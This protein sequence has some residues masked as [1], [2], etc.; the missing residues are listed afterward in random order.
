MFARR[1]KLPLWLL[2][3]PAQAELLR[4]PAQPV[5]LGQLDD[6]EFQ[7]LIDHMMLTMD[8]ANGIGLAAPQIG[9]SIRLAVIA[10]EVSGQSSDLVLINPT[11]TVVGTGAQ[12]V[13]EGCLSIPGVYGPVPRPDRV[14]LTAFDR[15]G[16]RYQL[17]AQDLFARV[18]QHENDHLE[19]RLF[20]DRASSITHGR[21][22]T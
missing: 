4:L 8:Q 1:T 12:T 10:H 19:G 14:K 20:I 3:R 5:P 6:P 13:E 2:K 17:S 16:Q 22:P 18:I 7:Q 15:R 11:V 21:V 9:Q